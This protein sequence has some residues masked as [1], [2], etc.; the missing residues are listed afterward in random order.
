MQAHIWADFFFSSKYCGTVWSV[1]WIAGYGRT[2]DFWL[3]ML[4]KGQVCISN[5]YL[6]NS[7]Y[8][9]ENGSFS[10]GLLG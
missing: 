2:A 7:F 8:Y 4:F 6:E 10:S 5:Y 1:V 3:H 9:L